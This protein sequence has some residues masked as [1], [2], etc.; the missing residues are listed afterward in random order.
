ME[1]EK[2]ETFRDVVALTIYGDGSVTVW[3]PRM[4]MYDKGEVGK[5]LIKNANLEEFE[6]E[7]GQ[8]DLRFKDALVCR[9]KETMVGL[10]GIPFAK[11]E[12]LTEKG[13]IKPKILVC[14]R[15]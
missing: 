9:A 3:G 15:G 4:K 6:A 1:E 12:V 5:I 10:G 11:V 13:W 14:K 8:I 2:V 7:A